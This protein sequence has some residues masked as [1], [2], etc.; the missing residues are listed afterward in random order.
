[1]DGLG[2]GQNGPAGGRL[3]FGLVRGRTFPSTLIGRRM[4]PLGGSNWCHISCSYVLD[5]RSR[6]ALFG[7]GKNEI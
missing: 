6:W 2:E 4:W 7:P 1:M 5:G 3:R